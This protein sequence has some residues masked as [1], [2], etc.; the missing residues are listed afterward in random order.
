V[1]IVETHE[2]QKRLVASI[3][4]VIL[5]TERLA[6]ATLADVAGAVSGLPQAAGA[7]VGVRRQMVADLLCPV[8]LSHSR[9]PGARDH[10]YLRIRTPILIG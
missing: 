4:P 10:F 7:G 3:V 8:R 5:A 2:Q 9:L 6:E 1:G